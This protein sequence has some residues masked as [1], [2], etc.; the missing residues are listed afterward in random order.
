M[1]PFVNDDRLTGPVGCLLPTW[2]ACLPSG[3]ATCPTNLA[4]GYDDMVRIY[5][6]I[7]ARARAQLRKAK[8]SCNGPM[9]DC[10]KG[11]THGEV[12]IRIFLPRVDH[13]IRPFCWRHSFGTSRGGPNS[14]I[15]FLSQIVKVQWTWSK[16]RKRRK[17]ERAYLQNG[18]SS[19]SLRH[20]VEFILIW[21][22]W[23]LVPQ[24]AY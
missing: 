23:N 22:T 14:S 13:G 8:K 12:E 15:V 16:V 9:W 21:G 6:M 3:S 2:I 19:F 1:S 20:A 5:V 4:K 7:Y 17:V 10:I 11:L 18:K 24:S